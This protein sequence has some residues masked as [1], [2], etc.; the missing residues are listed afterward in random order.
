MKLYLS[1]PHRDKDKYIG[2]VDLIPR[3]GDTVHVNHTSY[4]VNL[5]TW[6]YAQEPNEPYVRV[7]LEH[8]YG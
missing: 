7:H 3:K 4:R 2:D 8:W 1:I 5:V 6:V